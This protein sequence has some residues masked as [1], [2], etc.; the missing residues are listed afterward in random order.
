MSDAPESSVPGNGR[1]RRWRHWLL[2][3]SLAL[4]VFLAALYAGLW[5]DGWRDG[6]RHRRPPPMMFALGSAM[7]ELSPAERARA[8]AVLERHRQ[9][10]RAG[11]ERM[12]AARVGARQA[13]V[14][15]PFDEAALE[16]A[17]AEVRAAAGAVHAEMHEAMTAVA[18]ELPPEARKAM[19]EAMQR[20][21]ER[22]RRGDRG[23]RRGGNN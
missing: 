11:F 4:N 14:A 1:G 21:T 5:F 12:R 13:L 18:A 19:A 6:P 2:I 10:A 22:H 3:G 9:D 20:R 17:L 16:G 15:E 8:K 23:D 7:E